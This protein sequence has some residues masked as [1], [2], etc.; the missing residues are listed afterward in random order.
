M[1]TSKKE[2]MPLTISDLLL[3]KIPATITDIAG[4][5]R[6]RGR[7][8]KVVQREGVYIHNKADSKSRHKQLDPKI[9]YEIRHRFSELNIK[10]PNAKIAGVVSKIAEEFKLTY[11]QIYQLVA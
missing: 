8:R 4:K 11:A 2:N 1:P 7:P 10:H 5:K 6:G 3:G 9:V